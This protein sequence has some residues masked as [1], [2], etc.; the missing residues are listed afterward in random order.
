MIPLYVMIAAIAAARAVGALGVDGLDDWRASTRAGLAIMFLFTGAA[1]F[2]RTRADLVRMVPPRL[3]N[4]EA[5]VTLTGIAE[6]AGAAGL[7]IPALARWAALG[8]IALL[9]AMFPANIY[10]A[11][12]RQRI[13]GR[14]PTPLAI[15]TP[16]QFLWIALLWWSTV[17]L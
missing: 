8:L 4:P 12:A 17:P 9:V 7:L 3:P 2:T 15:R 11:R 10:A 1:H 13:A 6:L 16:L 14:P 5:L